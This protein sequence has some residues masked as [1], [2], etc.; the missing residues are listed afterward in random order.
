MALRPLAL[1]EKRMCN[2]PPSLPL[3][4]F[5]QVA[6]H[7]ADDVSLLWLVD[8]TQAAKAAAVLMA[9][10]TA[11]GIVAAYHGADL[12]VSEDGR[13]TMLAVSLSGGHASGCLHLWVVTKKRV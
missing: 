8:P 13:G 1:Y 3:P 6:Q 5:L 11:L 10:A 4:P 2:S 12:Q 7:T 9:N